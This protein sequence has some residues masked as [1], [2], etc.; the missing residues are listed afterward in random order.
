MSPPG[1][2]SIA[3]AVAEHSEFVSESKSQDDDYVWDVFYHRPAN[4]E[5]NAITNIGTLTGL[6][7]SITDP[8]ASDSDTEPEDEADEDSN[9]EEYYKNDYPEEENSSSDDSDD[10]DMFHEQS[11]YEDMLQEDDSFDER[12]W[13]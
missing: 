2:P 9:E 8:N 10:S 5:W 11:D 7:P 1:S 3:S 13:R 12:E 4:L 6:P